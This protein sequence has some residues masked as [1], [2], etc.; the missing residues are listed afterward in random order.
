[1]GLKNNTMM[2]QS[3]KNKKIK[4]FQKYPQ[5]CNAVVMV[6]VVKYSL[7]VCVSFYAAFGKKRKNTGKEVDSHAEIGHA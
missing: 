1:M 5:N 2:W 3:Q 6:G 7:Q 4:F